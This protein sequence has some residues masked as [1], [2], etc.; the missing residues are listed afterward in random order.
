MARSTGAVKTGG[1]EPPP[2]SSIEY[3]GTVIG[4]PGLLLALGV[5]SMLAVNC[6]LMLRYCFKARCE[7]VPDFKRGSSFERFIGS[8]L[9]GGLYKID[10]PESFDATSAE[11]DLA[12]Q[13]VLK[14][15]RRERLTAAVIW[16]ALPMSVSS[17]LVYVANSNV[18]A[19]IL[20]TQ[21]SLSTLRSMVSVVLLDVLKL[22]AH[23]SVVGSSLP[24]A[25][26]V[27]VA[28]A[29]DPL[30]AFHALQLAGQS[31]ALGDL[32]S[33]VQT[34][35]TAVLQAI[36]S[37]LGEGR[38][39]AV[40]TLGAV[41]LV[42]SL[43]FVLVPRQCSEEKTP[44]KALTAAS[45]LCFY[46]L[47]LAAFPLMLISS[48]LADVCAGTTDKILRA[49]GSPASEVRNM[50]AFFTQCPPAGANPAE[51]RLEQAMAQA[52]ALYSA[53]TTLNTGS[54]AAAWSNDGSWSALQSSA[55]S[56]FTMLRDRG[57]APG[58]GLPCQAVTYNSDAIVPCVLDLPDCS[59]VQKVYR[60][61]VESA[62]CGRVLPGVLQL[63]L[64]FLLASLLLWLCVVLSSLLWPHLEP[65]PLYYDLRAGKY[66]DAVVDGDDG[67][68]EGGT[69]DKSMTP[70]PSAAGSAQASGGGGGGGRGG[71]GGVRRKSFGNGASAT[72]L[73]KI[74]Q[75]QLDDEEKGANP[76][77]AKS[78]SEGEGEGEGDGDGGKSLEQK[79]HEL[80]FAQAGRR[81][82]REMAATPA[83][84]KDNPQDLS[85]T[86]DKADV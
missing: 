36:G 52:S 32:L 77:T 19:G 50:T 73:A 27:C 49:V 56:A 62:A 10:F 54:C 69:V 3:L 70:K 59:A 11:R 9:F 14:R 81:E 65:R 4:V 53:L 82:A 37:Y 7:C 63:G 68:G 26:A 86:V 17:V 41:P 71:G 83:T 8:E 2:F 6:A 25:Q 78:E 75:M 13:K 28:A 40:I 47:S 61:L 58:A 48:I 23:A 60:E 44:L 33:D 76:L 35:L 66:V 21:Q 46:I 72:K 24:T 34:S 20:Q 57:H 18:E 84:G 79:L 31:Q 12:L 67:G 29:A 51:Q 1:S 16:C 80:A 30:L 42:L 15:K 43:L 55:S 5:S 85:I 22:Q 39:G 64:A 38:R 45:V 74:A